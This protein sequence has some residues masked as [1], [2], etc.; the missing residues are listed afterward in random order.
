M[1]NKNITNIQRI[2]VSILPFLAET[3]STNKKVYKNIDKIYNTNKIYFIQI[4]KKDIYYNHPIAQE[5]NI[6]Q[7]YYFKKSLG[8][9]NV[10][11]QDKNIAEQ[12]INICKKGW[13]YVYTYIQQHNNIKPSIFLDR[14]IKKNKGLDNITDDELNSNI[15]I[16]LFLAQQLE[17]SVDE[18]DE[19]YQE[20]IKGYILRI[21]NYE[22]E[23][24][25]SINYLSK[26][27]LKELR[28]LELK[29]KN[30]DK[31]QIYPSS[32]RFSP[33]QYNGLQINV[34]TM[35]QKDKYFNAFDYIF[36]LE[37]IS[38]I[39][40]VGK[41]YLKSK[42]IQELIF[43]YTQ[44]FRKDTKEKI[45]NESI[46]YNELLKYIYPA[47]Q[48]RYLCREYK[49]AKKY[50]FQNFDEQL[51]EEISKTENEKL[52]LELEKLKCKNKRLTQKLD[53]SCHNRNE[54]IALREFVFNLDIETP[55]VEKS[56]N[57]NDLNEYK[58]VVIGGHN[59][60]QNKMKEV[61]TK[62]KFISVETI[63]FDE[64]ILKNNDYIFIN[65]GYMSHA[66]YYKVIS[67]LD[68]ID[69]KIFF[70]NNQNIDLCLNE[71]WN[72]IKG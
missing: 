3:F 5:G 39:S 1:N 49:K 21:Q 16:L 2:E 32:Y 60:W 53:K 27:K 69:K 72:K 70:I 10:A 63:N 46:D 6:E 58:G 68:K 18:S 22:K 52:K 30:E 61:L 12:V 47:I 33:N 29:I 51:Y 36:D 65:I 26:E 55:I 54:L 31:I 24:R 19:L 14:Y 8:I 41:N 17:K 20:A 71:I 67:I 44:F 15:V 28:R 64:N 7:E 34:D 66:M 50:F 23:N 4:A 25:I 11:K 38:L 45:Y 48:I 57:Y 43:C 42:D 9:L 13:K 62:W 56:I 35:S 40:I 59:S 37:N